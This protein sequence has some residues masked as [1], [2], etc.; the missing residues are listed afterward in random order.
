MRKVILLLLKAGLFLRNPINLFDSICMHCVLYHTYDCSQVHFIEVM[1][2]VME[3]YVGEKFQI[4]GKLVYVDNCYVTNWVFIACNLWVH[5]NHVSAY[6][7][8]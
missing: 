5:Y 2:Q 3:S 8:F 6:D 7:L 4:N 1:N